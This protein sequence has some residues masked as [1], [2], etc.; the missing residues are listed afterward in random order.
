MSKFI[1][2]IQTR[3]FNQAKRN[4]ADVSQQT[5]TFSRR[6]NNSAG[7]LAVMRK[8]TSMLRNNLLLYTFAVGGTVTAMGS[9]IRAASDAT[10]SMDK[11]KI[12]FGDF[13]PQAEQFAQSIQNSFGIAKSEMVGLLAGL[14][15]TFVPLGF[16][17]EQ[18]AELSMAMAQ[19][20][21]DVGSFQ[22]VATGEVA[23]A[24]TSAIVGNHEAV[25]RF[26]I[27]ITEATLK[28]EAM[29]LG[30]VEAG[31]ELD[32]NAKIIARLSVISR[33]SADA[34]NNLSKT[35]KEFANMLRGTQ[36]RLLA[37]TEDIGDSLMP[38]AKFALSFTNIMLEGRRLK[39]V[40]VGAGIAFGIY[41]AKALL[42][43]KAQMTFNATVRRNLYVMAGTAVVLILNEIVNQ[44]QKLTGALEDNAKETKNVDQVLS[45]MID[46][47]EDLTLS[48]N[49]QLEKEKE[50]KD[51]REKERQAIENNVRSLQTRLA[52][53]KEDTELGKERARV[54]INE[55]RALTAKEV[56]ALEEIQNIKDR[57]QAEKESLDITKQMIAENNALLQSKDQRAAIERESL[58]L[59]MEVDG[60]DAKQIENTKIFNGLIADT[61]SAL[62]NEVSTYDSLVTALNGTNDAQKLLNVAS[63]TANEEQLKTIEAL[64]KQAGL[65]AEL[66]DKLREK[67]RITKEEQEAKK[68]AAE[69]AARLREENQ[70]QI[71]VIN[72]MAGAVNI[73]SGAV[74]TLTDDEADLEDQMRSLF[75]VAGGLLTVFGAG[76]P[77]G[78]A[79]ALISAFAGFF[80]DGG[81]ISK[82]HKGGRVS[83][84]FQRF[85]SGG[86]QSDEVPIIAQTGEFMM[87]RQAVQN[88]GI[89]RLEQMNDT[90]RAAPSVS[91]NINGNMIG[92]KEFVRDTLIPEIQNSLD[93]A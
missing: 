27:S 38:F 41:A 59:Q 42:A 25:R 14:Q 63:A 2:E 80:H 39:I 6:A 84:N 35:Q 9:F 54:L 36:G 74:R 58:L 56:I 13:T 73:L 8:E 60:A 49:N 21:L 65:E 68:A 78:A 16:S 24:F 10:E 62:G 55:E 32:Q 51:S 44:Y 50:L 87:S 34:F 79:G 18:A 26:G 91:V 53:M 12:V 19:L 67:I 22:N 69:A 3:G 20:S 31:E 76:T 43:A 46:K 48:L 15:D 17:R 82:M 11:F 90:G 57:I 85:H 7:A 30:L 1:V 64:I 83:N 61:V 71:D 33:G 4:L 75:Q 72:Q 45:D 23:R 77:V 89:G 66:A 70:K 92:N 86:L 29:R 88:I 93:K 37:L 5:R 81:L 28:T 40:L 47:Q 52:V